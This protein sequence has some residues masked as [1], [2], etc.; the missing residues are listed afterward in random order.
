MEWCYSKVGSDKRTVYEFQEMTGR[1]RFTDVSGQ[2]LE[3]ERR[4]REKI[5]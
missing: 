1:D 4:K 5:A 2:E 3:Q